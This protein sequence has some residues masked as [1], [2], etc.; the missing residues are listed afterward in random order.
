MSPFIQ[1]NLEK[2]RAWLPNELRQDFSWIHHLSREA[3]IEIEQ[4]LQHA[5]ATQ[6]SWLEMTASDFPLQRHA[7]QA[8]DQ[9]FAVT[10]TGYGMCLLKGFPVER[11]SVEDARLAHWG[12]GLNVGVARKVPEI[13]KGLT[14]T[15]GM[16]RSQFQK[17]GPAPVSMPNNGFLGV[18][19]LYDRVGH[20]ATVGLTWTF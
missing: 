17:T 16:A 11:W 18:N 20:S 9:A 2:P 8:I 14:V 6:K 15:A 13:S 3:I 1:T 12:I 4:A 7:K 10:Q 19:P 5:K